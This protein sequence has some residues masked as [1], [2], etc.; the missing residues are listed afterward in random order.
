M[1]EKLTKFPNFTR[2]LPEK[3]IP[4]FFSKGDKCPYPLVSYNYGGQG[5][6][7]REVGTGPRIG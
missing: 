2:C 6:D 3:Y 4:D 1:N 5:K 7:E